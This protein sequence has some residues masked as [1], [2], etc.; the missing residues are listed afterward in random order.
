MKIKLNW[1]KL[2]PKIIALTLIVIAL[3]LIIIAFKVSTRIHL[4]PQKRYYWW[5]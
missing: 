1:D 3:A 5:R 2:I 4:E